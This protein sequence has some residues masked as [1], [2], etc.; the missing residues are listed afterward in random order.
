MVSF[1]VQQNE[2]SA[3]NNTYAIS[4][5]CTHHIHEIV[6]SYSSKSRHLMKK[7][8]GHFQIKAIRLVCR[9]PCC[10]VLSNF[11]I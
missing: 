1:I 4:Y 8:S 10:P 11:N 6:F 7:P 3:W 5:D 2:Y 9:F